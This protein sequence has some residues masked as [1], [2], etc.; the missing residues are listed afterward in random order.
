[1]GRIF[2]E[3]SLF[4]ASL[5]LIYYM[6]KFL[7]FKLKVLIRKDKEDFFVKHGIDFEG[8]DLK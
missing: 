2:A 8:K 3:I 4:I 6:Y 5:V 1:M 7:E